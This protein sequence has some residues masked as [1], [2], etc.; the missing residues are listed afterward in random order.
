MIVK[1]IKILCDPLTSVMAAIWSVCM[2]SSVYIPYVG[3][4]DVYVNGQTDDTIPVVIVCIVYVLIMLLVIKFIPIWFATVEIDEE[5]ICL[6]SVY[7]K[8]KKIP[9]SEIRSFQIAYY[10]HIYTNRVFVVM[11]RTGLGYDKLSAINHMRSSEDSV[12]IKLT[13]GTYKKLYYI[14]PE[15]QK[16]KLECAMNGELSKVAF[17]VDSFVKRKER[18]RKKKSKKHK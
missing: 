6:N 2:I 9:F 11:G 18:L 7:K 1:K 10:R 17:N 12:K 4:I 14:L 16:E 13:K 3:I 5:G 15:P 8:S